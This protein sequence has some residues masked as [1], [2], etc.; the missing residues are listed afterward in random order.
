MVYAVKCSQCL[1]PDSSSDSMNCLVEEAAKMEKIKLH[2]IVSI[3]GICNSPLG[4]VM[5]HMA[6]GSLETVFPTHKLSWQLKF[7][8][9]HEMGLAM[10]FLHNT[11][12][13]LLH[14]DLK[15]GNILLDGNVHV[16]RPQR[17]SETD[18]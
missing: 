3:Y 8:I 10:N 11:T 7:H 15:P 17:T 16:K 2:H 14:L 12:P 6:Q 18:T 1:L 5:G 4:I 13:P 9:I